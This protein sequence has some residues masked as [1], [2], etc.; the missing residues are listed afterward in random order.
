MHRSITGLV[1]LGSL[2][3]P[4][5]FQTGC[6]AT[7]ASLVSVRRVAVRGEHHKTTTLSSAA[8]EKWGAGAILG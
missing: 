2:S 7:A 1:R 8:S 3:A 4:V 6:G 5:R